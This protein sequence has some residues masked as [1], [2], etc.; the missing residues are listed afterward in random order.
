MST[1]HLVYRGSSS[2]IADLPAQDIHLVLRTTTSH[3]PTVN[4]KLAVALSRAK[5]GG[6]TKAAIENILARVSGFL[7]I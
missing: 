2:G 5:E 6:V 4:P 1:P 3:D 7:S